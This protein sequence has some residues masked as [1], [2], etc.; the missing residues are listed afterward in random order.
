MRKLQPPFYAKVVEFAGIDKT[1]SEELIKKESELYYYFLEH[2]S[3]F[4][5][6]YWYGLPAKFAVA[7][8]ATEVLSY[9]KFLADQI[10]LIPVKQ[11]IVDNPP[12]NLRDEISSYFK[13]LSE[14]VSVDV[15]FLEDGYLVEESLRNTD[16]GAGVPLIL[17][18]TWESDVA[19][20]K[21]LCSLK[22]LLHQQKLWL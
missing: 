10:G 18:S 20:D 7:G 6:E 13:N 8:N 17:G 4:F 16:F 21:R 3:N 5:S 2:F 14:G 11:I 22:Y 15:E 9:S 19:R 1:P 12:E